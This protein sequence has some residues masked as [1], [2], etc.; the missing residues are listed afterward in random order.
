M[1]N[2]RREGNQFA[3]CSLAI[4]GWTSM[5]PPRSLPA[6]IIL[7][8][9]LIY[10]RTRSSEKLSRSALKFVIG[11]WIIS[12]ASSMIVVRDVNESRGSRSSQQKQRRR[13]NSFERMRAIKTEPA[14]KT[15]RNC[16]RIRMNHAHLDASRRRCWHNKKH[17]ASSRLRWD[18]NEFEYEKA[19]SSSSL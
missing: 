19:S 16:N 9:N 2:R 10:E 18:S 6:P 1:I 5:R 11:I 7:H 17:P 13:F 4:D 8:N 15:A 3:I 14:L 12:R